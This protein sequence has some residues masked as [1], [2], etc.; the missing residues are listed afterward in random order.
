MCEMMNITC[1]G[2]NAWSRKVLVYLAFYS[3]FQNMRGSLF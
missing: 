3:D 1:I 2:F